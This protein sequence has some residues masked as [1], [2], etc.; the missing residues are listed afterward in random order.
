MESDSEDGVQARHSTAAELAGPASD[1][2]AAIAGGPAGI[3]STRA[4]RTWAR[5][6]PALFLLALTVVFVLQNP[7]E[8]KVSFL[9]FSGHLPLAVALLAAAGL[10]ALVVLA[11]GSIRILQLRALVRRTLAASETEVPSPRSSDP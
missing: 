6:L 5:I 4:A 2:D 7:R 1:H 10:G 8:S 9:M 11:L 3:P